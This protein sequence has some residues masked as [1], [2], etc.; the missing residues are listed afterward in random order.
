MLKYLNAA[1]VQAALSGL[2]ADTQ[3][4]AVRIDNPSVAGAIAAL[5]RAESPEGVQTVGG[6]REALTQAAS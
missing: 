2:P 5:A 3:I 6:V 4:V 1:E